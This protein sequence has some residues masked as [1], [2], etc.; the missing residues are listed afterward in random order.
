M[1]N[2]RLSFLREKSMN[3]PKTPGVY[4]MK[5][6]E[7]KVIYVGKAKN[8]KNRVSSYFTKIESHNRKTYAMVSQVFDFEIMKTKTE[9]EALFLEKNLIKENMPQYNVLLRDDKGVC[10]IALSNDEFPVLYITS[11]KPAGNNFFGPYYTRGTAKALIDCANRVFLL[12]E[13]KKVSKR[14]RG[15]LL[16]QLGRCQA[17]CLSAVSKENYAVSLTGAIKFLKGDTDKVIS[18]L[19]EKMNGASELLDFEKAAFYRDRLLAVNKIKETQGIIF[20]TAKNA[21]GISIVKSEKNIAVSILPIRKG[22]MLSAVLAV[23]EAADGDDSLIFNYLTSYYSEKENIPQRIYLSEEIPEME[24]FKD[25][26]NEKS[27][28]SISVSLPKQSTD[29]DKILS[30]STENAKEFLIGYEQSW[31][32]NER[33]G[34]ELLRLAGLEKYP[35]L[36]EMYD[37]SHTAGADTVG[38]LTVFSDFRPK[39]ENYKRFSVKANTTSDD[40]AALKEVICRRLD[41]YLAKKDGF[42]TLPDLFIADGGKAQLTVIQNALFERKI[43]VPI[44]ALKKDSHHRTKSLITEVSEIEL[45]NYREL[46]TVMTKL[47]DEVH[48]FAIS[49]HKAKRSQSVRGLSLQN[50]DG[51]GPKKARLILAHFKTMSA[52]RASSKQELLSVK[53][54]DKKTALKLFEAIESGKI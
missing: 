4:I 48:R 29:G 10:Y 52:L 50:V 38:G 11:K 53:G 25:F 27:G 3:L 9:L 42:E 37:I 43:N 44:I 23:P 26:I 5:N 15:C 20:K 31:S 8:L 2:E 39:R 34:E 35:H 33:A 17:P 24:L 18:F 13:C 54:L 19:T 46:W 40:T 41:D 45:K 28:K 14:Q 22:L 21:D 49:Y 7:G 36:I 6:A 12:P 51:V 30:Y 32:L 16:S 47:Q 1:K